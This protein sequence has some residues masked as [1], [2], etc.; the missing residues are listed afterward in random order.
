MKLTG[1]R[2]IDLAKAAL[3]GYLTVFVV[4]LSAVLVLF[5]ATFATGPYSLNLA[6]GALPLVSMWHSSAGYGF[7]SQWGLGAMSVVGA[8][9]A[10][11]L[12]LR[13]QMSHAA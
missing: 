12:A 10:V 3:I 5:L 1:D 6:I 8:I 9:A 7:D 4:T 13:R 11:G 2:A